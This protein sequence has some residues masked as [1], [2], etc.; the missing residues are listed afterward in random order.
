MN[1][2]CLDASK[3]TSNANLVLQ[4]IVKRKLSQFWYNFAYHALIDNYDAKSL[5]QY[6]NYYEMFSKDDIKEEIKRLKNPTYSKNAFL[7][8]LGSKLIKNKYGES[9]TV[10]DFKELLFN[11]I[12][13]S[14][15]L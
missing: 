13:P 15:L 4:E 2:F 7:Y 12:L 3:E 14:N 8:D 10:K 6:A 1:E 11:P 9:P 5:N